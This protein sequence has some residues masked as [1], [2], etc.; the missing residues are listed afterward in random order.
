MFGEIP[1][2]QLVCHTCDNPSCVNYIHLYLGSFDDNM[3]DKVERHRVAGDNHSGVK[4]PDDCLDEIRIM[5][6][7]AGYSQ[8]A[9]A[10]RLGVSQSVISMIIQG[11]R[12]V[13]KYEKNQQQ[14]G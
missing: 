1:E 4:I 3:Q 11:K 9:I 2:G 6:H 10:D 13:A 12:R 8:Q 7:D 5:Y 14:A